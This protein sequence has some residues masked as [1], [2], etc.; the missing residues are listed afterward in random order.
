MSAYLSTPRCRD[1]VRAYRDHGRVGS[2]F[3]A[4][5]IG[6]KAAVAALLGDSDLLRE[7]G[8]TSAA[9]ACEAYGWPHPLY[10]DY[11]VIDA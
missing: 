5:S 10:I 7:L 1:K 4:W 11:S 9:A 8:W 6:E 3:D 2:G